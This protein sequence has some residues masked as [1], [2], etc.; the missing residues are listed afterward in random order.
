MSI[1]A[2]AI[3]LQCTT[4]WL[5]MGKGSAAGPS[6]KNEETELTAV[7]PHPDEY[8]YIPRMNASLSAGGGEV[9]LS[10]GDREQCAFR[11]DWLSRV[12]TSVK[13]CVLLDVKGDSMDPTLDDG[14][15]CMVDRGRTKMR[16][17]SIFA[18]ATDNLLL[19][20]RLQMVGR[21]IRIISDNK[22]I[23]ESYT[24]PADQV[25]IIGQ[26]IWHCR[27]L[28]HPSEWGGG[29]G[30]GPRGGGG[31]GG[32]RLTDNKRKGYYA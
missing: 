15:M 9:V 11:R 18:I 13:N 19:A 24:L 32:G 23:Y 30:G 29:G 16:D 14:D 20:K 21:N 2:L 27:Q 17:G 22:A 26:V 1:I 5:L 7:T 8:A 4:D 10:E 3:T 31:G 25:R 12:A 28:V 6:A